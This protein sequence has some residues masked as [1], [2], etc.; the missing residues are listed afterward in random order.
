M[1]DSPADAG[2]AEESGSQ[3]AQGS[4]SGVDAEY[5][6]LPADPG[7]E[8]DPLRQFDA[9]PGP[10]RPLVL[11]PRGGAREVGRSCL[12]VDSRRSRILV[13]AGI[14]AG[15]SGA[16]HPDLRGLTP[17]SVDSVVLTHAHVDHSGALPVLENRQL[18]D[19]DARIF[20]TGPT[21]ALTEVMLDDAYRIHRRET[22]QPGVQQQYTRSDVDAVLD[23]LEP[24]GYERLELAA[25]E[26]FDDGTALTVELGNAGHLLGSAWVALEADGRRAVVSGDLGG[27]TDHL[28]DVATPPEA[29]LLVTESTYGGTH[30]HRSLSDAQ[31]ELFEIV[32]DAV[33]AG[34]PVLVPAFAVGRTQAIV[35]TLAD[36]LDQLGSQLG[37]TPRV[38]VDGLATATT[39]VYHDF[40]T[41]DRYVATSVVNYVVESGG[42]E[43]FM[44]ALA[45]TPADDDER[46]R[47]L[48]RAARPETDEVP[49][50]VSPSGML[51]GGHSP[52]YLGELVARYDD[53]R[54]V[55]VGYQAVGSPGRRLQ[56]ALTAAE[57][58]ATLLLDT[59]PFGGDWP[60]SRRVAWVQTDE[61]ETLTRLLVPTEWVRQVDGLS[62]HAAQQGLL[63]F[64]REVRPETAVLVHG[65]EYAQGTFGPFLVENVDGLTTA[66]RGRLLTPIPVERDIEVDM[67]AV[68]T[69]HVTTEQPN[70]YD[71]LERLQTVVQQLGAEVAA[72]RQEETLSEA[73]VRALVRDELEE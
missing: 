26:P 29:D 42:T 17:G 12:Q 4:A 51:T 41:D 9:E 24:V 60:E 25:Y 23:R 45:T 8:F 44:P 40:V 63:R 31:Q 52:Q 59:E 65:P 38:V 58:A 33:A 39:P 67:A 34:R 16:A 37:H 3:T 48:A 1:S 61:G 27:R 21:A 28:P 32:R 46:G 15:A 2:D 30:N 18:L 71:E 6:W 10:E 14:D 35:K 64:A 11:T 69:D 54:V 53:A 73:E 55:L 57:P 70:V 20:C 66:A 7:T 22:R 68:T 19:D 43:P 47:L 13:D 5:P 62:A 72:L 50:I 56:N 36:R 49:V